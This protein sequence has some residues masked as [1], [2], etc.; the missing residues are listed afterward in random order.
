M[1]EVWKAINKLFL[2]TED[3]QCQINALLKA[4]KP[5]KKVAKKKRPKLG[6]VVFWEPQHEW[7]KAFH[8]LCR[9]DAYRLIFD[10]DIDGRKL[11]FY[12]Q[13]YGLT[14]V[15]VRNAIETFADFW[16]HSPKPM[17]NPR[18]ALATWMGNKRD[19]KIR[20]RERTG[21]EFDYSKNENQ[22]F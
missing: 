13:E 2:E 10:T 18:G 20:D 22:T 14:T 8:S 4:N 7:A 12:V 19:W 17:K 3:L 9:I 15:E 16:E 1:E 21:K 5:K 6:R 11:T